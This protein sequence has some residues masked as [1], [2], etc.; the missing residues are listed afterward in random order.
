MH[1]QR[2]IED[3]LKQLQLPVKIVKE[4]VHD[5]IGVTIGSD[6]FKGLVDAANEQDFREKLC[7]LKER[8][9]QFEIHHHSVPQGKSIQPVFY[10]WFVAEKANVV[11]DCMLPEVRKKAG[12]GEHS[13][14]FY[15]NMCESMNN[16]LKSRTDYK[17]HE[18]RPF[19]D[20]MYS[21]VE[22]QENL[23]RKEVIRNDRW[24][25]R[26]EFQHLE[27]DSDKWFSLSEKAQKSH[28]NKMLTA[29]VGSFQQHVAEPV[30][31]ESEGG[32]QLSVNYESVI[33]T[34]IIPTNSLKDMWMK[35]KKLLSTPGLVV[36]VPGQ[37]CSQNRM[38]ASKHNEPHHIACKSSGQFVCSGIC[39]RYSTYRICLHTVAAA[40]ATHYLQK[41]CQW[42]KKQSRSPDIDSLVM[43]GLPKG[44]EGQKGETAK[45][46]RKGKSRSTSTP[47]RTYDHISC[48]TGLPG[49]AAFNMN[50]AYMPQSSIGEMHQSSVL[51]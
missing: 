8:W 47:T 40:E 18:L 17:E 6:N 41:F 10:D 39:P 1:F 48:V 19:V 25:F 2:N 33:N 16:T 28:I 13:D 49:N 27:V 9:N 37:P 3:K 21:F 12:L 44:V 35:A 20:K 32:Q 31:I 34:E 43:S 15:T 50:F 42:W 36:P 45:C 26:Q 24:R 46:S 5:I 29:S 30:K 11:V 4:I 14:P 38:V 23:I 7:D 22:S 51:S